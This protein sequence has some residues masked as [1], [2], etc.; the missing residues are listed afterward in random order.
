MKSLKSQLLKRFFFNSM[1]YTY[2]KLLQKQVINRG[3]YRINNLYLC[4]VLGNVTLPL[5][6]HAHSTHFTNAS[7][8]NLTCFLMPAA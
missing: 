2:L 8:F 5:S 3:I 4:M 7:S 1:S 6:P